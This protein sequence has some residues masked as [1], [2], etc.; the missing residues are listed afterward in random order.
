MDWTVYWFMFP[1]C[2]VIAGI[3]TFSGISG[4]ALMTP[5]FLVAFPLMVVPRLS[6][7]AAI[8]AALFL[9]TSGF[10][11]GVY[12]Y[13]R[14][15]LVDFSTVRALAIVTVPGAILGALFAHH[16]PANVLRIGYGVAMLGIVW[17][18]G[19][20]DKGP[21]R[22]TR[23][24][25]PCVV[26]ESECST[27]A[28]PTGEPR[29]LHTTEGKHYNW[30]AMHMISLRVFSAIGAFLAGL[31]STGVGE[32]TLLSLVRRSR[33][34]VP[35]ATATSTFVVAVTVVAASIAHGFL[36]A[37][38]GGWRAIPWNLIVWGVPG[39]VIGATIGT[40]LQGRVSER[41]TRFFFATLFAAI[42]LVFLFAFTVFRNRFA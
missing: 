27:V 34:P 33:F 38:E 4:A 2:I 6:T 8:G 32:A 29:E 37:R 41:A 13:W 11:A 5:V 18:I 25:C 42:G 23:A 12:H 15:R 19:R 20:S 17:L 1:A 26:C 3:A 16:A 24:P 28:D 10:G 35:V 40:R 30:R 22:P 7:V 14:M 36:L 39:A 31:I 9:E 21:K